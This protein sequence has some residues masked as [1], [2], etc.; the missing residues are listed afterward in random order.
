MRRQRGGW[1]WAFVGKDGRGVV[2]LSNPLCWLSTGDPS[3]SRHSSKEND[4]P[5]SQR[6]DRY[7][8]KACLQAH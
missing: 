5:F 4:P 7:R 6:L 1:E 2:L 8:A 3:H